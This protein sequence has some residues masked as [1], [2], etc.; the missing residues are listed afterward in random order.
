MD[1]NRH[2]CRRPH[3]MPATTV[4]A[5]QAINATIELLHR[6]WMMRVV[7]ELRGDPSTFRVLQADCGDLSP[8]VLNQRLAELR[9][10]A[11]VE[12]VDGGYSLT[13]IGR[14]LVVAFE[15][16]MKWAIR[17]RSKSHRRSG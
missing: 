7:W 8:T 1:S 14:E 3:D 9:E 4:S 6:R 2:S 11:L 12:Q 10:A 13:P 15:P 5:K 16:L 17:W